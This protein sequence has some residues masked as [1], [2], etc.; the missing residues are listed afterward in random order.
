MSSP[1]GNDL[2]SGRRG[3]EQAV[4]ETTG[5]ERQP[6]V[7]RAGGW[8]IRSNLPTGRLASLRSLMGASSSPPCKARRPERG[9]RL[10]SFDRGKMMGRS[11]REG[12]GSRQRRG[13]AP[14]RGI[15]SSRTPL[16]LMGH[17]RRARVRS[18]EPPVPPRKA[19]RLTG[20]RGFPGLPCLR[21]RA[22]RVIPLPSPPTRNLAR[23]PL[24][25]SPGGRV[26]GEGR[27]AVLARNP[28]RL[29]GTRPA[30][31]TTTRRPKWLCS[32]LSP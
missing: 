17:A 29:S 15:R 23:V 4:S 5:I 22:G 18:W 8:V 1:Q 9:G 32:R 25:P 21:L 16:P 27:F 12:R 11:P 20:A 26:S 7:N 14:G 2:G 3:P 6:V 28:A 31:G 10:D 13:I 19:V 30:K 24:L